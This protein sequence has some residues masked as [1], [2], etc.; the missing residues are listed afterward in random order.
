MRQK[1][2]Y[3]ASGGP[4]A[5]GTHLAAPSI[6]LLEC[7]E[8]E[9]FVAHLAPLGVLAVRQS[10]VPQSL[11]V[12]VR[13]GLEAADLDTIR[14]LARTK[15]PGQRIVIAPRVAIRET[16]DLPVSGIGNDADDVPRT[17]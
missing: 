6:M 7:P 8:A 14:V 13:D 16:G 12:F 2:T 10:N 17:G 11:I 15:W 5:D 1:A 4:H 3:R 9:H